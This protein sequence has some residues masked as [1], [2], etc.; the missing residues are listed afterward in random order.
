MS[1]RST[2]TAAIAVATLLAA[3]WPAASQAGIVVSSYSM[4]DGADLHGAYYDNAY[5]GTRAADG[6]LSGGTGDLTD[7]VTSASVVAG[8]GAWAPYVLWDG[9]SPTIV[10]DL[11]ESYA[12]SSIV[13]SFKYYAQAAV[14]LPSSLGL[15]FSSD[16][17]NYGGAQLRTLSDAER[18]PGSDNSDGIYDVLAAPAGGRYVELTLNNGPEN[19]WLALAEVSFDGVPGGAPAEG[20]PEPGGLA[21]ALT[22]LGAL[23]A[24][25]RKA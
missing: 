9:I 23:A 13:L 14:Y 20:L 21:L 5:S 4:P 22:A 25:R 6:T 15:R 8:Y 19:R 10:F 2:R 16:G 1:Q 24:L 18:V 12:I 11:G 7:G 3:A 17:L